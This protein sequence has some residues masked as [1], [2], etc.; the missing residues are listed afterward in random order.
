MKFPISR[1]RR[2]ARL[3]RTYLHHLP[4]HQIIL[5]KSLQTE[6]EMHQT[7]EMKMV[8]NQMQSV[9]LTSPSFHAWRTFKLHLSSLMHSKQPHWMMEILMKKSCIGC[10][11]RWQSL[12]TLAT[13]I[14]DFLWTSS[15]L[16]P[17][18]PKI[19]ITSPVLAYC[20]VTLMMRSFRI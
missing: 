8:I 15:Y 20:V 4:H 11:N 9:H 18:L 6:L 5:M 14:S 12:Q 17:L 3:R 7:K 16:P 10:D 13:P 19:R 1:A 2:H